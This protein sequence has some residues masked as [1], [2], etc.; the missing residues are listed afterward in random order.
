MNG[1]VPL[2]RT[3]LE[4]TIW[5]VNL[6]PDLGCRKC[7]DWLTWLTRPMPTGTCLLLL[8]TASKW[9]IRLELT[10]NGPTPNPILCSTLSL[11]RQPA[12][13]NHE[14]IQTHYPPSSRFLSSISRFWNCPSPKSH[15]VTTSDPRGGKKYFASDW[16]SWSFGRGG[17]L[18]RILLHENSLNEGW[19]FRPQWYHA[20]N[21]SR[22]SRWFRSSWCALVANNWSLPLWCADSELRTLFK[23]WIRGSN[24]FEDG[25]VT[26]LSKG[27]AC[28]A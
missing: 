12:R 24:V 9:R 18:E 7:E 23:G 13:H 19:G 27:T 1:F 28:I 6:R 17:L 14:Q 20:L 2:L 26:T 11:V 5:M 10:S 3:G 4:Y 21:L 22:M 25:L 8:A 16:S 15:T